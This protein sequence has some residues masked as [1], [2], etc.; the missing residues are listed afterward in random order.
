MW[1]IRSSIVTGED[2]DDFV[3]AI[4]AAGFTHI[5]ASYDAASKRIT[6]QHALGG[7][8]YFSDVSGTAMADLGFGTAKANSYGGNS[9]LTTEKIANLFVAPAGDK[10]DY[11]SDFL[12]TADET[13]RTFAFLASNWRP[14]ENTPDQGTT[15]TAIQSVNEPTKDPADRQKWYT[16][17]VGEVDILIHN[18]TTWTGYQNVSSDARGFD[19]SATDPNGP[20]V[21]WNSISGWRHMVKHL[22][23]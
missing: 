1:Q 3:T 9:D 23:S 5:S 18:G 10:D 6:V 16:T 8:I 19:L 17:E 12:A 21:S 7:N 4:S 11:S 20:I 22:R 14:V 13:T 2:A 15:F